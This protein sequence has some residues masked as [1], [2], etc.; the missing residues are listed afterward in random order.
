MQ[1]W[2]CF[3]C[4]EKMIEADIWLTYM[5]I[6]RPIPGLKCPKCNAAYLTEETVVEVINRGEEEIELKL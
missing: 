2:Y 4:K 6:T 1:Q 5:E 3:K